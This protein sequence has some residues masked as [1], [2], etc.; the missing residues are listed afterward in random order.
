MSPANI[1]ITLEGIAKLTDFGLARAATDLRL[2]TSGV[3]V[4]S[5]WYMSPEQVRAVDP[6]DARTDIYAMGAVLHEML[7][8]KKL[9]EA[10]GSFEVMRAQMETIP[11]PPSAHN[12]KVPAALD[13]VVARAVAKDPAAR[14]QSAGEFR[15]T[16]ATAFGGVLPSIATSG[17]KPIASRHWL[18]IRVPSGLS[19]LWSQGNRSRIA[20][21]LA[22]GKF[23][24]LRHVLVGQKRACGFQIEGAAERRG[25]GCPSS[26]AAPPILGAA[27]TP[28][29][30]QPRRHP[31]RWS[32]P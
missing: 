22:P 6:L 30:R 26:G 16:V 29:S 14:F 18:A 27:S 11:L 2:T 15:L 13:A 3:A 1:I 32:N 28:V 7:T 9:F 21:V 25:I 12:P 10:N 24:G 17:R 8:G 23:V 31:L 4:G 19:A 5:R 20:A